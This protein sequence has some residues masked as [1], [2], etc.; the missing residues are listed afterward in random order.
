MN[1]M[2]LSLVPPFLEHPEYA[3]HV[4]AVAKKL[5]SSARLTLQ[6]YYSAAV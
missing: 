4:R 3:S 6:C 1:H 2:R 5:D